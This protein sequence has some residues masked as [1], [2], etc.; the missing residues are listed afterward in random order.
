LG[1]R[2][3]SIIFLLLL[4]GALV[5]ACYNLG[6]S[7]RTW[8]DEGGTLSIART[9]VEDGVYAIRSSDGYQTFGSVQSVGPTV[10]LPIALSFKLFGVGLIQGRLVM[11]A[12]LVFTI[13]ACYALGR[14][15]F[16][17]RT[18][19]VA[20]LLMLGFPLGILEHGRQ[21]LGEIPAL[22]L[23]LSGCLAWAW[24]ERN[25]QYQYYLVTGVLFGLSMITKSQ[26][27][28]MIFGTLG[29]CFLLNIFY[30]KRDIKSIIVIGSIALAW[31]LAW[32]GWQMW[33]FGSIT[34]QENLSKLRALAS[35]TMGL[36]PRNTITALKYI[37]GPVSNHFYYFFGFPAMIYTLIQCVRRN[38]ETTVLVSLLIFTIL[39]L[40]YNLVWVPPAPIYALAPMAVSALLVAKLWNDFAFTGHASW[41]MLRAELKSEKPGMLSIRF[42]YILAMGGMLC[43]S[44]GSQ[45][46]AA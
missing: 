31:F 43:F 40:I 21:A 33:Y 20:V 38:R 11:A 23:F 28:P 24:A 2:Q 8:Q 3:E 18:A 26:Y 1:I 35:V 5:L 32:F 22:G 15:L 14:E 30:Y 36:N 29:I 9:L 34:F 42:I 19:I 27:A 46:Q 25:K 13:I 16:G 44:L 37:F 7:P 4:V 10:I 6:Q 12:W 41:S 17:V 39:C 45:V